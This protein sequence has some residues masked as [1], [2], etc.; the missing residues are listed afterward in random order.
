MFLNVLIRIRSQVLKE[1]N[2]LWASHDIEANCN[3]NGRDRMGGYVHFSP[4]G[5]AESQRESLYS[6][7]FGNEELRLLVSSIVGAAVHP[8]DFPIELRQYGAESRG[9]GC[10]AD[11]QMYKELKTN[12]ELVLTVSNL[13]KCEVYWYDRANVRHSVWPEPNSLTIVHPAS[14]VHCVGPTQGGVR[15]MLKFIMVGSYGKSKSFYDYVD[16]QCD[17]S[18]SNVKALQKRRATAENDEL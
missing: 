6:L 16:N 1:T 4:S 10:H 7:I 11:I 9:M 2:R 5:P 17:S 18:N 14:V 3:L 13:G 8:S 15:E 12:F